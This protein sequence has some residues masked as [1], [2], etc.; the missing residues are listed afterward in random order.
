[1]KLCGG[2]SCTPLSYFGGRSLKPRPRERG[3]SFLFLFLCRG[4]DSI[5]AQAA[6]TQFPHSPG[7][8]CWTSSR[9]GA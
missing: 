3:R 9:G 1:M 7:E 2:T 6:L 4:G 8:L 5:T